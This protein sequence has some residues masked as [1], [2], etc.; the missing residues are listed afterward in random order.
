MKIDAPASPNI[1]SPTIPREGNN[2]VQTGKPTNNQREQVKKLA[3]EFESLFL[4]IIVRSMRQ[5]IQKSGLIDGGNAEE[6]YRSLLDSEYSKNMA[7]QRTTGIADAIEKQ[8]LGM[9]ELK[10]AS[11]ENSLKQA[12]QNA[13]SIKAQPGLNFR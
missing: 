7:A 13:Y 6:I 9:T 10:H 11:S 4:D 12:A 1:P 8:L 3:N 2:L 5:S